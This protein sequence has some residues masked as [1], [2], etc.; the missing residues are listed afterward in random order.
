MKHFK[1]L[2]E[3]HNALGFPPPENPLLSLVT[4]TGS[5]S[6]P[7]IIHTSDFYS[8]GFKKLKSGSML[9]GK[10]LYDHDH[11]S[12]S[13]TQPR[14]VVGVRDLTLEENGFIIY[15]HED[16]LNGHALHTEIKKY[17]FFDYE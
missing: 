7:G 1:K 12:M 11:G 16:L 15:F 4:C 17:N 6:N 5:C 2:G 14:Q 3:L 8:I 13:F 10:T 9:Y